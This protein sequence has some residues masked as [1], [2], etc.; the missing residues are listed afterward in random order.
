MNFE[1]KMDIAKQFN[2][3]TVSLPSCGY[4]QQDGEM[5]EQPKKAAEEIR[6]MMADDPAMGFQQ[7]GSTQQMKSES[8]CSDSAPSVALD[9][10]STSSCCDD[11]DHSKMIHIQATITHGRTSTVIYFGVPLDSPEV[12]QQIIKNI[13]QAPPATTIHS[14]YGDVVD[15]HNVVSVYP[16]TDN[17]GVYGGTDVP[18][19]SKPPKKEKKW[20]RVIKTLFS[21]FM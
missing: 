14:V 7:K 16:S 3:E 19:S 4:H 20:R 18:A 6:A 15:R 2:E 10:G 13:F 21:C 8:T 17:A 5:I 11:V 12:I 1:V 9:S